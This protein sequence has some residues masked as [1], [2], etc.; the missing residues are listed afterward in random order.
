MDSEKKSYRRNIF[1][2]MC[3]SRSQLLAPTGS[4]F[5]FSSHFVAYF[6]LHFFFQRIFFSECLFLLQNVALRTRMP[7]PCVRGATRAPPRRGDPSEERA[8]LFIARWQ[9]ISGC[10]SETWPKVCVAARGPGRAV[11]SGVRIKSL[12]GCAS[13]P[14]IEFHHKIDMLLS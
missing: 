11:R 9:H 14:A 6:P 8:V 1:Q 7:E 13:E 4:E 2:I 10:M 3:M 12:C 5:V